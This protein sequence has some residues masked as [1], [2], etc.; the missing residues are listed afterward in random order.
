[1]ISDMSEKRKFNEFIGS[2]CNQM[3]NIID[4]NVFCDIEYKQKTYAISSF[5]EFIKAGS[6]VKVLPIENNKATFIINAK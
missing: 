3:D 4:K 6:D 1:M 2:L 5:L